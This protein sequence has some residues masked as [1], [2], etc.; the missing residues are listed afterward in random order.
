VP[1]TCAPEVSEADQSG[2]HTIDIGNM[3]LPWGDV[4]EAN[5]ERELLLV[6]KS[7]SSD[8]ANQGHHRA[9]EVA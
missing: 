7:A 9:H 8:G 1:S 4:V 5:P 6:A 3:H 2:A